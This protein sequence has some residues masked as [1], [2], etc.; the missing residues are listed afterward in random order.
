[1]GVN[2]EKDGDVIMDETDFALLTPL[3]NSATSSSPGY[4]K[5]AIS[6][7]RHSSQVPPI[8]SSNTNYVNNVASRSGKPLSGNDNTNNMITPLSMTS[9]SPNNITNTTSGTLSAS[10]STT[11]FSDKSDTKQTTANEGESRGQSI[12]GKNSE[13][14]NDMSVADF[15][16]F[17]HDSAFSSTLDTDIMKEIEKITTKQ[18]NPDTFN[19][20]TFTAKAMPSVSATSASVVYRQHSN[21]D[22]ANFNMPIFSKGQKANFSN[23]G[24]SPQSTLKDSGNSDI[25]PSFSKDISGMQQPQ[26]VLTYAHCLKL[27]QPLSLMNYR[28]PLWRKDSQGN[29]LCNACGLFQK[30]HGTMRPLSLKTDVIKKR[31]SRRQSHH[32]RD[33]SSKDQQD[34]VSLSAPS[35]SNGFKQTQFQIG[36]ANSLGVSNSPSSLQFA[37]FRQQGNIQSQQQRTSRFS[38][39]SLQRPKNIPILP[40]P[41]NY[42]NAS[43]SITSNAI[44]SASPPATGNNFNNYST[45]VQPQ[46]IPEFKRRKSLANMYSSQP[47]SPM[48]SLSGSVGYSP[49][50]YSPMMS[51]PSPVPGSGIPSSITRNDS[52]SSLSSYGVYKDLNSKRGLPVTSGSFNNSFNGYGS[53]SNRNSMS[54]QSITMSTNTFNNVHNPMSANNGSTHFSNLSAGMNAIRQ[55]KG[56]ANGPSSLS[57]S[58][59]SSDP[60]GNTSTGN[61]KATNNGS[62]LKVN[63]DDLEWLKFDV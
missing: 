9:E 59:V 43:I 24:I 54:T 48:T 19:H 11:N 55:V 7:G 49:S 30:L 41:P 22:D 26:K 20:K 3:S 36:V 46:D 60:A 56:H 12:G 31:N 15:L 29:T 53:F 14:F 16:D 44:G 8:G 50:A 32:R 10:H 45:T 6:Q 4:S 1:M 27:I 51:V 23:D 28:T 37:S 33:S 63:M 42:S 13:L 21:S 40:K 52:I 38:H 57:K 25:S 62:T 18:Q 17:K 61:A 47:S 39:G 58:V 5:N 2:I 34:V 35:R